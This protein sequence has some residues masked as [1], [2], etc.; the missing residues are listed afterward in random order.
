[1]PSIC[2]YCVYGG[3]R[4]AQFPYDAQVLRL[5]ANLFRIPQAVLIPADPSQ[6]LPEELVPF[7]TRIQLVRLY[8]CV[9]IFLSASR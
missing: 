6:G 7:P 5:R 1:M 9:Y 8:L 2:T 4:C 3:W